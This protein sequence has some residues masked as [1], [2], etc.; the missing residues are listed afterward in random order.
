M[1]IWER[2]GLPGGK[3]KERKTKLKNKKVVPPLESEKAEG[4]STFRKKK[5]VVNGKPK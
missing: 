3:G 1:N 4:C 2:W 5:E